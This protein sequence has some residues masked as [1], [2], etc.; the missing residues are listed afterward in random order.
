MQSP[1]AQE[2]IA[3]NIVNQYQRIG[4]LV[5]A[6]GAVLSGLGEF[7]LIAIM[8]KLPLTVVPQVI[9]SEITLFSAV[10]YIILGNFTMLVEYQFFRKCK[11]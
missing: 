11:N 3:Q 5:F 2:G 8:L 6:T 4:I 7:E 10:F 1:T 9:S